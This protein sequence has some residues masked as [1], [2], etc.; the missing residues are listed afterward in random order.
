MRN[1]VFGF[2]TDMDLSWWAD[3][4]TYFLGRWHDLPAQLLVHSAAGR[5]GTVVDVG[6]NRGEFTLAAACIVGDR[7]RVVG[8]EADPRM[9]EILERDLA[10]NCIRNVTVHRIGLGSEAAMLTLCV[11]FINSGK[12]KLRRNRERRG[13][14]RELPVA[15]GDDVLEGID[16][17]LL[18]STSKDSRST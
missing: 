3:R 15:V 12:R 18:R 17:D 5:G 10:R 9:A 4:L 7:G 11:P 14:D 2:E 1:K 13:N 8:F 6:A 16:P